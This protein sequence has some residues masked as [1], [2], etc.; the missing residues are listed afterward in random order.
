[1]TRKN[2]IARAA[3]SLLELMIGI[4]ILALLF[5]GAFRLLSTGMTG[6]REAMQNHFI[7]DDMQKV[8]DFLTNDI[9]ESSALSKRFPPFVA[10]GDEWGL[11]T[12]GEAN[13]LVL[14]KVQFDFRKDF[15]ALSGQEKFYTKSQITYRVEKGPDQTYALFRECLPFDAFGKPLPLQK[16]QKTLAEGFDEF[17]FFRYKEPGG[18]GDQDKIPSARGIFFRM[19][20]TNQ[21]KNAP[22]TTRY[23]ANMISSVQLRGSEPEGY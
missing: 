23:T 2:R 9:H 5:G 22:G 14:T 13:K 1:M 12:D 7:N 16:V 11:K 15:R 19:K 21:D 17:V 10:Q 20:M 3:F 18:V 6:S 4:V 8:V